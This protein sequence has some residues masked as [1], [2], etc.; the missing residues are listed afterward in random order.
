M[1]GNVLP[2]SQTPTPQIVVF[3]HGLLMT[4]VDMT[5]LRRRV[6]RCGF[7]VRQFSY[8]SIRRPVEYNAA[9]LQR[10][11]GGI[12]A[13]VV[14]L[15]GHSLGGL[16][17]QRLLHDYPLQ[18]PGR[19]VTFGT[20][21][22]GSHVAQSLSRWLVGRA[23]MGRSLGVL[24]GDIPPWP[25]DRE[26]G[27]IAGTRGIGVGWLAPGLGTPND[28][29]VAVAETRVEAMTDHIEVAVS[30]TALLFSRETARQVCAFLAGGRFDHGGVPARDARDDSA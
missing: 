29:T 25:A 16:V 19:V 14:H 11:L 26:L 21:H 8:A 10:Y 6:A 1:Q 12:D 15:V 18:R 22:R 5:L 27:V 7:T 23:L 9:R 2:L 20:P 13:E 30:H 3:V 24:E 28:G 17:I 4:G